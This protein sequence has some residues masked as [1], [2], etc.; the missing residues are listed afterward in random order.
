MGK[1]LTAESVAIR[2]NKPLFAVGVTDVGVDPEKVQV[3]LERM[4]ELAGTWEAVLLMQV[5]IRLPSL[6]VLIQLYSDEADV[7]LDSRA[8]KGG[9]TDLR[10]NALV[11]GKSTFSGR[12]H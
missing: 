9:Q 4:F 3:N 7:F 1:T 8:S 6:S 5:D 12:V 10:R 2:A 11:S